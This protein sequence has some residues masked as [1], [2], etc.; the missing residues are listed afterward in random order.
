MQRNNIENKQSDAQARA[1][2]NWNKKNREKNV[3]YS[4][5]SMCKKYIRDYAEHSELQEVEE[6]I[7]KKREI[8]KKEK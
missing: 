2:H 5:K 3:L 8:L 7:A 4:A 6:W 1:K